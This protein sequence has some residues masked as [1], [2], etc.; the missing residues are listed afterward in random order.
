MKRIITI[1][2]FV[3]AIL[4]AN[5]QSF[6]D[7]GFEKAIS[8]YNSGK[9]KDAK[10]QFTWCQSH[11]KD[12]SSSNYQSWIDK[13]DTK[14]NK[15]AENTRR[16]I[17]AEKEAIARRE[18]EAIKKNQMRERFRYIHITAST[19]VQGL[20]QNI[21]YDIHAKMKQSAPELNFTNDTTLAYWEVRVVVNINKHAIQSTDIQKFSVEAFIEVENLTT[22]EIERFTKWEEGACVSD[23]TENQAAKLVADEIYKR[24]DFFCQIAN[25]IANIVNHTQNDVCSTKGKGESQ[26]D[27]R[28]VLRISNKA[29]LP[30]DFVD[31]LYDY[32]ESAFVNDSAD[33]FHL[34]N[35]S[36]G[37]NDLRIEEIRYE[38]G[39][40]SS[41]KVSQVVVGSSVR[42]LCGI[43]ISGSYSNPSF[44]CTIIDLETG[45]IVKGMHA[46][47]SDE[48]ES[49]NNN[50]ARRV[51]NA[52]AVKLGLLSERQKK[53][54]E[55]ESNKKKEIETQNNNAYNLKSFIPGLNQLQ[56]DQKM[57]G[58][59]Y[60]AGEALCI[61]GAIM[62]HSIGVSYEGK[63][64]KTNNSTLKQN[65]ANNANV[66]YTTR[67]VMIGAAI[68][69]YVWNVI[70]AFANKPKSTAHMTPYI[71]SESVGLA[72]NFNF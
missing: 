5:G 56:N 22:G 8:L 23:A 64:D 72:L 6:C 4:C 63:I 16:R 67:N 69:V 70:D 15:I 26:D 30:N 31:V 48:L 1:L 43:V 19:P 13:C 42:Y 66:C 49:L 68:A 25:G 34:L 46:L 47:Y 41:D 24:N 38:E 3:G 12:R 28:T 39:H 10:M 2:F 53:A 61:G 36:D 17:Q 32:M 62:M 50:A 54:M 59:L 71:G 65:Y 7:R 40:H 29:E 21:E 27:K 9:Y 45:D 52:L 33:R 37:I 58:T 11:C 55:N 14:I 20:F 18:A 44:K 57:K 35:R 60:I 51:A